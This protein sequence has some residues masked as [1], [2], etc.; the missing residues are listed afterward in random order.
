MTVVI[1]H[2]ILFSQDVA[3]NWN[4]IIEFAYRAVPQ[5]SE[6]VT[7]VPGAHSMP[8]SISE[9]EMESTLMLF[10]RKFFRGNEYNMHA[11]A[12]YLSGNKNAEKL[13][14]DHEKNTLDHG[15]TASLLALMH[16]A[17]SRYGVI[18][19]PKETDL[20]DYDRLTG[21]QLAAASAHL[22]TDESVA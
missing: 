22:L 12:G 17:I 7:V 20:E 5:V 8:L 4:A 10:A 14:L 21:T 11:L 18:P 15:V 1:L 13:L 9:L 3:E 6:N 2:N 19:L 16:T